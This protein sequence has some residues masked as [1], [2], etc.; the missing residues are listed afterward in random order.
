[1]KSKLVK[2]NLPILI[3]L[4]LA[5][6]FRLGWLGDRPYDGDEGVLLKFASQTNIN[7]TL[8]MSVSDAHPP[9][10]YILSYF[11]WHYL[12]Q[13]EFWSRFLPALFGIAL[14]YAIYKLTKIYFKE[15]IALLTALLA[16]FSPH[17]I[18]FSQEDRTYSLLAF[19]SI[20]SMY[21][22]SVLIAKKVKPS[23]GQTLVKSVYSLPLFL[24]L[25]LSNAA[26]VYTHHVGWIIVAAE[27]IYWLANLKARR[28]VFVPLLLS[29]GITFL[30]FLPILNSTLNQIEGRK[31]DQAIG[32][33]IRGSMAGLAKAAYRF[34][35]GSWL[36]DNRN[37][38]YAYAVMFIF[39]L[40]ITGRGLVSS[41]SYT[42]KSAKFLWLVVALSLL[43]AL[44]SQEIGKRAERTL[45]FLSP[46]Y[47]VYASIGMADWW[48]RGETIGEKT[49][50]GVVAR[51][52]PIAL[53]L[54]FI[55]SLS[56]HYLIFNQ[57]PGANAIAAFLGERLS[58]G[59]AIYVNGAFFSGDS[60][61]LRY[62]LAKN[63]SFSHLTNQEVNIPIYG[64]YENY[65]IGNLAQIRTKSVNE[66]IQKTLFDPTIQRIWYY[67][68]SYSM[69]LAAPAQYNL[70]LDKENKPILVWEI[71]Q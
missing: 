34:G 27:I 43:A 41:K 19:L 20:L 28:K 71:K 23:A 30:L 48:D 69:P 18:S 56:H 58:P 50:R 21:F 65:K 29:F 59:D 37:Q 32:L 10:G 60:F 13:T 16:A 36:E 2:K 47:L 1:M 49:G 33:S 57:R 54:V 40:I 6:I 39:P 4:A 46:I 22:F 42:Q 67:D 38:K 9:L 17:L 12:G 8:A 68:F 7:R 45:I 70:G 64:Y 15:K 3:I 55:F 14:I 66:E 62:Y 52:F 26:L 53:I 25:T 51:L 11:S 5:A 35:G 61:I 24:S 63:P 44:S 31:A